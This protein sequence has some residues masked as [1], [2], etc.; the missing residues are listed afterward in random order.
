MSSLSRQ[1]KRFLKPKSIAVYGGAWAENVILQLQKSR[2]HGE[3]WAVHPTKTNLAGVACFTNTSDLPAAPDAAF[4]GVNRALTIDVVGELRDAKAGGVICFASGFSEADGDHQSVGDDLQKQLITAAG[5]M[6]LLGPNCYGYLNY[7]DNVTLWPDQHGGKTVSSG[8]AIIAQSSNVAINLTMQKRGLSLAYMFT[9]GNQACVGLNQLAEYAISDPRISTIGLFIE[10]FG[11]LAA[12]ESMAI[13]AKAAGKSVVAL[14]LGKSVQAQKATMTHTATLAGGSAAAAAFLKR[15][16]IV[17]VDSV[18]CFIET[19]KL[20]DIVGPLAGP[21]I[22]SVSCSGGEASLI[23]DAAYGSIIEFPDLSSTQRADLLSLLGQKVTLANPL[24]YHTYVWGD[25]NAMSQCF[26][27]VMCGEFD[28]NVFVLDLPRSD[29]CAVEGHRC[30]IDAIIKAK[31]QTQAKVAVVTSLPE[32]MDESITGE[33]H[34]AG[35]VVLHGLETG[36]KPIVAAVTAGEYQSRPLTSEPVYVLPSVARLATA[37]SE[38]LSEAD[39]K[40][41]LARY[42]VLIP[43]TLVLKTKDQLNNIP[44]ELQ[45]PLV[46]KG[47]GLQH[48][49]E[50]GAVILGIDD[51]TT[52]TKAMKL[53][54]DCPDGYLLEQM[55]DAAIAEVI[56]GVTRDDTGMLMLTLGAGGVLTELLSDSASILMPASEAEIDA[57]LK[58]LKI[59]TVLNGYRGRAAAN[60]PALLKSI[61]AIQAYTLEHAER[62]YELDVNPLIVREHDCYAVDALIRLI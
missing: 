50:L 45:F 60:R 30:A 48:K 38:S 61:L 42:G 34:R 10:G 6:P 17:E 58:G 29:L 26:A 43:S 39:A 59:N 35:V 24:D 33:F 56:V 5:D 8:V 40:A 44:S 4:I 12:F 9:V 13:N 49:S 57:A 3:I 32:N 46:L 20:L 19:L 14:K 52:L 7:L 36:L 23:A 28:L 31:Q 53:I 21:Q 2:Y 15:L 41:E 51:M 22:S 16:G 1:L 18:A 11:D 62:I 25:V 47:L 27:S 37:S 54:V 55:I